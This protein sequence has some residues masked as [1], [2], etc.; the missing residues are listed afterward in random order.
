MTDSEWIEFLWPTPGAPEPDATMMASLDDIKFSSIMWDG[1]SSISTEMEFF[2]LTNIGSETAILNG[3]KIKRI[4]SGD[5]SFE[6]E[7]TNLQINA[8]S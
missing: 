6:S 4:A 1:V 7:I 8:S 5:S 2:E 3:W